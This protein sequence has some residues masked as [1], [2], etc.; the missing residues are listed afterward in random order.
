MAD[1]TGATVAWRGTTFHGVR[2]PDEYDFE[3][4][5]GWESR[6]S[7]RESHDR[8]S[9]HGAMGSAPL[10]SG[11]TVRMSGLCRT[12]AER[13]AMLAELDGLFAFTDPEAPAEE[14][15]VTLAG[16]TLSVPAWVTRY[17][18]PLELWGA[19]LFRWRVE[20]QSDKHLRF[21]PPASSS[22]EPPARVGGLVWPLFP[23][24][25]MDWG[26]SSPSS[27]ATVTN[28]GTAPA[29]VQIEVLG[30]IDVA[31][32][33]VVDQGSG[34]G[35]VFEGAVAAGSR[36]LLD[37]ATGNVLLDGLYDRGDVLTSRFWPTVPAGG[38]VSLTF[39]LRGSVLG[40]APSMTATVRPA[41]W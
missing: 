11:R 16:R 12:P 17:E 23:D 29:P 5:E 4:L 30:P 26:T 1:L 27:L 21:G 6:D 32:F 22:A 40:G 31:G 37:G 18:A 35:L 34:A 20:F 25:V 9:G 19:G 15:T 3:T 24:G 41:Y 33:E 14:L 8:P 10:A 2:T 13:D 28:P 39:R 36:L 7:R 38:S